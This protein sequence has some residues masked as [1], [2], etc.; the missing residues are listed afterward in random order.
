MLRNKYILV[1][2]LCGI[3]TGLAAAIEPAAEKEIITAL[4]TKMNNIRNKLPDNNLR[5]LR[6][7]YGTAIVPYLEQYMS[8]SHTFVR[9]IA[10]AEITTLIVDCNDMPLRKRIVDKLVVKVRD[11]DRNRGRLARRL[12]KFQAVD[13][14]DKSKEILSAQLSLA[15]DIN[16]MNWHVSREIILLVGA[17]GMKSEL[18][19]LK[20]FLDKNQERFEKELQGQSLHGSLSW[21][22]LR[23]RARMGV[24]EDI[25]RCIELAESNP[26]EWYKA[27]TLLAN[28]AYIRQPETVGILYNYL[29]SDKVSPYMG[30]DV[31][32]QR[33]AGI[34]AGHLSHILRGFPSYLSYRT[35]DV[36]EQCRK[37][38]AEQKKWDIIR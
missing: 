24:K 17:A 20:Q 18:P 35:P 34:A 22:V 31:V 6:K 8:D 27:T 2:C 11:D 25:K 19:R 33:Y 10:Y 14:S 3:F 30:K 21:T 4:S 26:D 38:M 7:K 37:W 1:F 13:F 28:L 12:L 15:L 36:I 16:K 32:T 29:K 9:W 5:E 23:A